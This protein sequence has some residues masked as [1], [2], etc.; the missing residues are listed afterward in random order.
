MD[1]P[2]C[3]CGVATDFGPKSLVSSHVRDDGRPHCFDV[4]A[5]VNLEHGPDPRAGG[6]AFAMILMC[7]RQP[8]GVRFPPIVVDAWDPLGEPPGGKWVVGEF[9]VFHVSPLS[10]RAMP[11]V[12]GVSSVSG[13]ITVEP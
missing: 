3:G 2:F 10:S 11:A 7:E 9:G 4:V 5:A 6:A 8:A 13:S 1:L 12:F